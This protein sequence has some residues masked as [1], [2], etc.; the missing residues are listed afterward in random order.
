MPANPS[1]VAAVIRP[2]V[3]ALAPVD[4]HLELR[5]LAILFYCNI[6]ILL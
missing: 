4:L 2:A 6:V 3:A 1:G 5:Q